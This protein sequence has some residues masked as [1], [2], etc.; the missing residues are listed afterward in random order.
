M[1]T[2]NFQ[3]ALDTLKSKVVTAPILR[4]PNWVLPFHIHTNALSKAI[5]VALGKIDEMLPYAI[6][7]ISKNLSK[8]ELNYMVTKK[9]LLAIVHSLNKFRHYITCYHTFVHTDKIEIR[10]LMNKP[11]VNASIIRWLLLLQQFDLTIIDKPSKE[12]VVADFLFRLNLLVGEGMVDDQMSDEHLFSISVLSPWFADIAKYLVSTQFPPHLS[13][14]EKSK[15]ARKSTS[16]TWIGGNLFKIGLD[17]IL[18][19]CVKDEEVFD[20]LRTCHDGSCGGHF[21][22]KRIAFKILQASYYWPTLHQDVRR[23]PREL[24]T[25]QGSQFTSKLIEDLL[26]HHR[27]KHMI[28][29]PYHPQ[30]NG[31]AEV[32]N[33]GLEGILTKVVSSSRKD[34]EDPL[35]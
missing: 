25:D 31:Q 4:G 28:S 15:I 19:R 17:Q 35:V 34:W 27:I 30:A 21:A 3:E 7:F 24:I 33:R 18:R 22:T 8:V 6:Y 9:E 26:T 32:T 16:F 20:I 14:K 10:Y 23:Y 2:D 5:G 12:N 29:T 1:W 11:N 13:S